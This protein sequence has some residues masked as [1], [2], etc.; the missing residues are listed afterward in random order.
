MISNYNK[1]LK[2]KQMR[3]ILNLLD[4]VLME[5]VGLANRKPGTVFANPEGDQL[6]FQG[7]NFYPEGGGNYKDLTDTAE[8]V[9]QL[10]R[11][12]GFDP[13]I[14][15]WTNQPPKS[16]QLAG[17][18]GGYAGFGIAT[19][20]DPATN[21]THYL[22]R[23]FKNINPIRIE[24]N[25]PN[26]L[27]GGYKLQTKVAQ[28]E[29]AG[30]KPTD[31]LGSNLNNLT[32]EDILQGIQAKFGADSDEA[33]A[34]E[35]FMT[36]TSYPIRMPLGNMNF[37][38]FTNYFC[39]MLQPMALVLGH[40]TTGE[41]QKAEKDWLNQGGYASCRITFGGSKIGGLTDST[42][43]NPAGQV[44]GLSSKAEGGAK[45]SAKNLMDK[46]NEMKS[47][48]NGQKLL[49]KYAKEISLIEV[50]TAGSTP[51]ALG[52]A[53]LAK[54]ITPEE[55]DQIMAIRNLPPGSDIVGQ[56]LLSKNL[57][58]KYAGR[59]ARDPAAVIPFYHIR[60]VV[61]NEVADWV[62]DNTDFG[63]AAAEILNWG[64]FIQ[65]ETYA[66]QKGDEIVLKPFNVIY[67]SVAVTNVELSADKTFYSTGSKGNFTFKI[68]YNG[69]TDIPGELDD[70]EP[71]AN[72]ST[73]ALD[74][75]AQQTSDIKA[76]PE[77][78]K[79]GT[80]KALGRKRQR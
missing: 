46:V 17:E 52:T 76:A 18:G 77:P 6:I 39:E 3:D 75:V 41:A 58:K 65:V 23:W 24:N 34:T 11:A 63:K 27:P 26:L 1:F 55:R 9:E 59:K 54:L 40:P 62:N 68:L 33:R 19:F 22:G 15:E 64:A 57:E 49:K 53:V 73:Q 20:I 78:E 60:A 21:L 10:A 66:D 70:N 14:I 7:L 31:V 72:N 50:V 38:A 56:K 43:V 12:N 80:E 4:P 37:T 32:P 67:P 8:A 30:Y 13:N 74:R 47:D 61:A 16:R 51:G 36:S 69:A 48:P 35:I 79:L 29:A 2:E 71:P 44:M 28:K 45:A 5:S 42:L 25:F